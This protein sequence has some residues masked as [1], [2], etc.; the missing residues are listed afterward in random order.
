MQ[1]HFKK[2]S[3]FK[4]IKKNQYCRMEKNNKNKTGEVKRN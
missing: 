1:L 4:D 2:K 3:P